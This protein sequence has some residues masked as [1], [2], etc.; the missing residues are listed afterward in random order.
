MILAVKGLLDTDPAPDDATVR[1][2]LAGNLCRCGTYLE[3]LAAVESLA[4]RGDAGAS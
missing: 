4:A 1:D 3:V 2:W